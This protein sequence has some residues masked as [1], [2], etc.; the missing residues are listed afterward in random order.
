MAGV[1]P[2]GAGVTM[3][4]GGV[5]CLAPLPG[6]YFLLAIAVSILAARVPSADAGPCPHQQVP[7]PTPHTSPDGTTPEQH[8]ARASLRNRG[9]AGSPTFCVW[10]LVRL[11]QRARFLG[12]S[13]PDVV[14]CVWRRVLVVYSS[15][16]AQPNGASERQPVIPRTVQARLAGLLAGSD[17]RGMALATFPS[18]VDDD[19]RR[20][21]HRGADALRG[22]LDRSALVWLTSRPGVRREITTCPPADQTKKRKR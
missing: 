16:T 9:G 5:L 18:A 4:V 13:G 17:D 19:D 8:L 7:D 2:K 6:R 22:A 20:G 3:I 12:T 10:G 11:R 1:F 15:S 21:A 14:R